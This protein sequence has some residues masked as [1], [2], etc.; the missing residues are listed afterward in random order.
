M[1]RAA[2]DNNDQ[3]PLMLLRNSVPDLKVK[4]AYLGH[5]TRVTQN[6]RE[7]EV[8]MANGAK[9]ADLLLFLCEKY[10]GPFKKALYEP[11]IADLKPNYIATVNGYL[12][13]QLNGIQTTL[14]NG[15]NVKLLPIVSGG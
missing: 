6:R 7:E 2:K 11:G 8:E 10:D 14:K 12:L 5:V 9:V 3:K 13:N 1:R 15:D 4:V